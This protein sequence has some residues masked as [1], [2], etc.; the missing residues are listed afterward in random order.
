MQRIELRGSYEAIGHQQALPPGTW[1]PPPPAPHMLRFAKRCEESL[2]QHGPEL[3]D[4]IRGMARASE[5][6][7]DTLLTFL[8]TIPFNPEEVRGCTVVAVLPERTASGS[9][10]F[11]RNFDFFHDASEQGATTY[12]TYPQERY[13]SVGNCDIWVGR[14]DGL[15]AAGLFVGQSA[16]FLPGLQPGLTFWFVGRLLLDRCATVNEGLEFLHRVPHAGSWTY[17]LADAGGN[18]AVVEPTV[19]GVEVRYAD[20]GLLIMTNHALCP[21]W[22]GRE[23][24]V[25]PDSRPRYERLREL[26]GGNEPVTAEVVKRALRDHEG[27]ICSHGAH[28]PNRSFGTIWSVA[29]S[30]GDRYLEIASGY[31]CQSEYDMV[32]F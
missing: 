22:A 12:R 1:N 5:I 6:D 32:T 3:L 20:D 15:N 21:R 10:L 31:P 4:E 23:S 26:L 30:P 13:A 19:D 16:C 9:T 14:E 17:L 11:G 27:L 24:F 28:F 29:G 8:V 7:Y 18:A 25:P 2:A